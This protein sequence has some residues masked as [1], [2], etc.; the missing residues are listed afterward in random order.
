MNKV[1]ELIEQIRF[2]ELKKI[3][4]LSKGQENCLKDCANLSELNDK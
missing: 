2:A 3:S 1:L 4:V